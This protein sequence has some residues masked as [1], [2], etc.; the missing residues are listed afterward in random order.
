MQSRNALPLGS[1]VLVYGLTAAG[2]A[3]ASGTTIWVLY[4]LGSKGTA[5]FIVLA[6]LSAITAA[7]WWGGYGPG[8]FAV[9][10]SQFIAPY[11]LLP[12]IDLTRVNFTRF[13]LIVS[14]SLMVSWLRDR[15][16]RGEQHLRLAN[17]SL[18]IRVSE[19]T[20]ELSAANVALGRKA[21]EL[22]R[23][24]ADLRRTNAELEQYTYIASHDLQEPARTM[25][26]YSQLLTRKHSAELSR[27]AEQLVE[28]IEKNARRLLS[29]VD[30]LLSYSRLVADAERFTSPVSLTEVVAE[31]VANC[32]SAIAETSAEI[33]YG[34]LPTVHGFRGELVQ[35][36]QNLFSN[37]L[38]YR[39]LH[40]P[41]RIV[42]EAVVTGGCWQFSVRDN[43]IGLDMQYAE[44][45]FRLFQR[46]HG[47]DVPGTG[48]GLAIC[49]RIVEDHGGTIWVESVPGQGATFKFT[50]PL[51]R[52]DVPESAR[53]SGGHAARLQKWAAGG[54]R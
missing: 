35:V 47:R 39:N 45:I 4:A 46:L 20:A 1:Y 44:R 5:F 19:R 24:N 40:D 54:T 12:A 30:A 36:F 27:E 50:L 31:A 52:S 29:I 22:E 32:Q 13:V 25:A 33:H 6:F 43:G 21:A 34:E 9:G 49:K 48:M 28:M 7:A 14:L 37:A 41:P 2:V 18:E 16:V 38:K 42:V 3:A 11:F 15:V 53:G 10:L 26:L 23:A 8:L 51:L 17:E